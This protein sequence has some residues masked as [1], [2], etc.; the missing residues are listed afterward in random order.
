MIWLSVHRYKLILSVFKIATWCQREFHFSA[1]YMGGIY[2]QKN[3]WINNVSMGFIA[4]NETL[5]KVYLS[6][7]LGF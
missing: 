4:I 7:R 1:R 2:R 6:L 5:K 3:Y